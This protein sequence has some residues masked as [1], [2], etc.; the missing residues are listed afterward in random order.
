MTTT[1]RISQVPADGLM[2]Y[3]TTLKVLSYYTIPV[4]QDGLHHRWWLGDR[5]KF[6]RIKSTDV[7]PQF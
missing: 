5:I 1:Q 6:K 3:D 4:L 7:W 2:V